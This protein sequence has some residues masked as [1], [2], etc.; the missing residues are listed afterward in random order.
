M[1]CTLTAQAVEKSSL[2]GERFGGAMAEAAVQVSARFRPG[3][4]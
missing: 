2:P 1:A 4:C 3:A